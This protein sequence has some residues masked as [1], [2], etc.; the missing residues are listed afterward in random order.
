VLIVVVT[1]EKVRWVLERVKF[2]MGGDEV[3]AGDER[4]PCPGNVLES[5]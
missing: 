4:A 1:K 2:K 5:D 3:G